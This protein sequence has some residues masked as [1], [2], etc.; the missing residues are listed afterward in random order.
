LLDRQTNGFT[1]AEVEAAMLG[2]NGVIERR[3]RFEL[4]D[5]FG[6]F[7]RETKSVREGG[8]I[9]Y[10]EKQGI[11]R[12]G[13]I[14]IDEKLF[15]LTSDYL[16]PN[17]STNTEL[18]LPTLY[19]QIFHETP[20][21]YWRLG[22]TSGTS[23]VDA[24]GNGHTG[25]YT[26]G[27]TLNQRSLC[28]AALDNGATLFNGSTGY[29]T[30]PDSAAFDVTT[31]SV[32][33]WIKTSYTAL[34]QQIISRDNGSTNRQFQFRILADGDTSLV[35]YLQFGIFCPTFVS[36][37]AP[38]KIADGVP[39]HV[40]ATYNGAFVDIYVDGVRVLHTAETRTINT[41]NLALMIGAVTGPSAFFNGTIDE[42]AFYGYALSPAQVRAR[43]QAGSGQLFEIDYLHDQVKV[44]CAIKMPSNGTDGTPWAE[45]PRGMFS[46]VYPDR[47]V[48]AT[49]A[50][51][52]AIIQ[53]ATAKLE[54]TTVRSTNYTIAVTKKYREAI[55]DLFTYAGF[56]STQYSITT[57]TVAETTL[58]ISKEYPIGTT[59]LFIMNELLKEMNYRQAAASSDGIIRLDPWLSSGSRQPEFTLTADSNSIINTSLKQGTNLKEIYNDFFLKRQ[60][61]KGVAQLVATA[62]NNNA[63]HPTSV[64]RVGPRLYSDLNVTAAD[65]TTINAMAAKLLEEKSRI[66]Y[67][68]SIKTP[69]LGILD[70]DD[71]IRVIGIQPPPL[72]SAAFITPPESFLVSSWFEPFDDVGDCEI[73]AEFYISVA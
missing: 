50:Y 70:N 15:T 23:A 66:S 12:G 10:V 71:F 53:D 1:A 45:F 9:R 42:V 65:Q 4:Y 64:A 29:V 39:H 44:Y 30:I 35:G 60:G 28:E 27:F 26:G 41:V 43:Y 55:A 72:F 3:L 2:A 7:L 56:T 37:T 6:N 62:T 57:S 34:R 52:D 31:M 11:R 61:S 68:L 73:E 54:N 14:Q 18:L 20:I 25:T 69:L 47:T 58:P 13:N 16:D 33:A 17:S 21:G 46:F 63:S 59:I 48:E 32:E 67:R 51:Y 24:S 36:F 38:V 49:G 19:S 40:V 22:D 5:K 8:G